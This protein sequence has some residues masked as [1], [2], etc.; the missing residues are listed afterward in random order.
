MCFDGIVG[1]ISSTELIII[2]ATPAA[3]SGSSA[4]SVLRSLRLFRIF[5][6][7]KNWQSLQSLLRTIASSLYEIGNFAALLILFMFIYSLVGMQLLANRLRF[8]IENGSDIGISDEAFTEGFI[9]RSHF[10]NFFWSMV[11]VFQL[12]TGENWNSIMYDC[13]R[14]RGWIGVLF[15]VS[16]IVIGVF[17][18]MNLFLAILL[19]NFEDSGAL[20]DQ[21]KLEQVLETREQINFDKDAQERRPSTIQ[22]LWAKIGPFRKL[23]LQVVEN[24]K[25]DVA[26]TVIIV[27]SSISLAIDNPLLDPQTNL[28]KIL[29]V[30]D[31]L[32]T[33]MFVGELIIKVLAQGLFLEKGAY[34]RDGWNLLDFVVVLVSILSLASVGPGNSL[35]PLRTLRVLRPL[36]MVKRLPELKVVVDALLLSFP[37]VADVAVL[38]AL[39]FLIFASFGVNF[40]KGTFYHCSGAAFERLTSQQVNY[41]TNPFEWNLLTSDEEAWFDVDVE[42]CNAAA[43]VGPT[44]PTSREV[45]DCLA[46][47][48]WMLT[49]PQTFDNVLFGIST[50]FEISTTEGWTE[51]MYAA[52]DQRGIGMQPIKNS[53]PIWALFFVCFLIFGA[54]FVMELFVGVTIDN[55][56]KIRASTGKSLMTEGQKNWAKT[57]QFVMK[58]RPTRRVQRPE[59]TLRA[60]CYDIVMPDR[61]PYFEHFTTLC[62]V[63]SS[64]VAAF[65]SFGDSN[66]KSRFLGCLN[67]IFAFIFT[68]EVSIKGLVLEKNYFDDKW[69]TFDLFIVCG[70]NTGLLV[71]IFVSSASSIISIIRLG[72]ICRLFRLVKSVKKLR[73]LFNTMLIA[74]PR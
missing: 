50:L 11:T 44:I 24:S 7:A 27:A 10:D 16:L 26:M 70:T 63:L 31:V 53:N 59:G 37:S 69:N 60:K 29:Q 64:A 5:K 58:I 3:S 38:C 71:G 65:T 67:L 61:N 14:A 34:L 47:G 8:S 18:V 73:A 46:P 45:C 13:W 43:W 4:F 41:L 49:I 40:L 33:S 52:I 57:Q 15:I 56:N 42:G 62:I 72:R 23:C 32:F 2:F 36:R 51:V 21:K 28:V 1:I 30:C 20:V 6:M 35:K 25:F 54:F 19:K 12:L 48:S 22:I 74:I 68:V 17:I 66:D 55:F 39:F 9:P